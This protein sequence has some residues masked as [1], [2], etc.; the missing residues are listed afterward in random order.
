MQIR[1]V[2]N[3]KILFNYSPMN[4]APNP[5]NT[6]L[7][8][9]GFLWLKQLKQL[10]SKKFLQDEVTTHPDYPALTSFTDTLIAGG[11][12]FY[13]LRGDASSVNEYDYP[14]LAHIKKE[15]QQALLLI[16]TAKEW[17]QQKQWVKYWTGIIIFAGEGAAFKNAQNDLQ[18]TKEKRNNIFTIAG[19]CTLAFFVAG[20]YYNTAS[21]LAGTFATLA[22]AGLLA[23]ILTLSAELGTQSAIVKQ[24]CGAVSANGC[25]AVLKSNKAKGIWGI[26]PADLSVGWFAT[27]LLLLSLS[28]FINPVYNLLPAI[29]WATLLGLPVVAWS[30]YTQKF[31]VKQWCALCLSV[32][33]VLL[34]QVTIT[35]FIYPYFTI[36][37][38]VIITFLITG[39]L[40]M[41]A[42][43]PIKNLLKSRTE[44]IQTK[45]ELTRWKKDP[46][47][48]NTLLQNEPKKDCTP[49]QGELQLGNTHAALQITVA[50]NTYCR[51]CANA[52]KKLDEILATYPDEVCLNFRFSCSPENENDKRTKAVT[53]ILQ[54]ANEISNKEELQQMLADWFNWMDIESRVAAC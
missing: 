30:L 42:Y 40:I 29:Y 7:S 23:S 31:V 25:G 22:G 16:N 41:L 4:S 18:L 32:A 54:K 45:R 37:I 2:F 20:V 1:I 19:L 11:F 5:F 12:Q 8:S 53:A 21:L 14:L 24:V 34:F 43:L 49:W 46:S 51:P 44:A 50:C 6:E 33:A 9:T 39:L 28:I 47:I 3:F 36:S 27:Q 26:T 13:A 48:F 38:S 17:G 10:V 35:A 52:H 15:E